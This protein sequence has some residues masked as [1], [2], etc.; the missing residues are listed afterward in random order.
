MESPPSII[1]TLTSRLASVAP[2]RD[3]AIIKM[4]RSLSQSISQSKRGLL[5]IEVL[6]PHH[7]TR[8]VRYRGLPGGYSM[9]HQHPHFWLQEPIT[10]K[11]SQLGR[12]L[13][14]RSYFLKGHIV[15]QTRITLVLGNTGAWMILVEMPEQCPSC[16]SINTQ[17]PVS[18]Y[19]DLAPTSQTFP[20]LK[21]HFKIQG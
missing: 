21:R 13:L 17:N 1:A 3:Q 5:L 12:G 8:R 16:R 11:S 6:T 19:L 4:L 9:N 10:P 15:D 20:L 18:W 2:I 14:T 7:L